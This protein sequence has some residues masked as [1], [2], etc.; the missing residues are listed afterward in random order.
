MAKVYIIILNWNGQKDTMECLESVYRLHYP[1]F[2]VIVVDNG[3]YDCSVETIGRE[4]PQIILIENSKNL[5]FTGGN[6]VGMHRAMQLG[7]DY[8]WLLNNDTVVDP[9]SLGRLVDE[10][11]NSHQI[12]M[13]SPVVHYYDPPEKVQFMGA[14]ADFENFTNTNV[15]DVKELE[16]PSVQRNLVLWG[17]ALLIKREVIEVIG[18]LSEK[19]FA[20]IEDCDFSYRSLRANFRARVRLDARIFH[21]G[22][23]ST[24]KHSPIQV[25]LGTR[26]NY[27]LWKDHTIGFRRLYLPG[28]YIGMVI[29]YA[30]CLAD[31]GNEKGFDACLNGYWAAVR[32][33]GGRYDPTIV[34]PSCLRLMFRFFVY[35]HPYFWI[36]LL[37][38]DVTGMVRVALAKA[39]AD[40]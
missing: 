17:T 23:Q 11:E 16:D 38:C 22:S 6:N 36:H 31:E 21:K 20:Y 10:A 37:R 1:D 26:N 13:V 29:N 33:I 32:G 5:G 19:Y 30:K 3:S 15:V 8:V 40:P 18:Y 25:Y 14:Y 35:W 34:I 39:Q 28:N 9:D 12:G 7:A 24:G 2:H 4:F 27:F